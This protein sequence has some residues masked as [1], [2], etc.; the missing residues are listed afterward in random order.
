MP[1]RTFRDVLAELDADA[2]SPAEKGRSFERLVKAFLEWDKA[3]ARRFT[4][5][6]LWRDWP[7]SAGL[8]P[9]RND[10]VR[11]GETA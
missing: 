6:W 9:W 7:G 10:R 8:G 5:V 4:R 2:Q 11:H 3:Q 1:A